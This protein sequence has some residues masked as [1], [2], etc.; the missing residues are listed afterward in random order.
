MHCAN[1]NAS[2]VTLVEGKG[3]PF[4]ADAAIGVVVDLE[5][6]VLED[7]GPPGDNVVVVALDRVLATPSD[8]VLVA[9]ADRHK[10]SATRTIGDVCRTHVIVGGRL[11]L[12][13]FVD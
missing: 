12:S 2:E 4:K 3:P 13:E 7:A 6:A 9:H 10:A 11:F 1:S 8:P 5:P